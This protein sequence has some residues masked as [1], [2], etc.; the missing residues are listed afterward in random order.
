MEAAAVIL[1]LGSNKMKKI[2]GNRKEWLSRRHRVDFLSTRR[3]AGLKKS[4][5]FRTGERLGR[6][7][8]IGVIHVPAR[9]V[10]ETEDE[11]SAILDCVYGALDL[12]R[13]GRSASRESNQR[14]IHS[15]ARCA[16]RTRAALP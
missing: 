5:K 12:L 9:L 11:R 3:Q 14:A 13:A 16:G 15:I 6:T 1:F 10:A 2:S 8:P 4:Y 7:S